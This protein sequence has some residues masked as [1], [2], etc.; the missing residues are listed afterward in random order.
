MTSIDEHRHR[1]R[2]LVQVEAADAARLDASIP[3]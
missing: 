1:A 3:R 2:F